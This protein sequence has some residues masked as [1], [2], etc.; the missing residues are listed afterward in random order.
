M[1]KTQ[2]GS[3]LEAILYP[4]LV[5]VIMWLV[6]WADHL[7][8][9]IPFY[10]YGV[11]PGVLE[12]WKGV[13][14]MPL[15]HS[16]EE[17]NHIFNNSIPTVVLLGAIIYYYRQIA[18]RVFFFSWIFTGIGVWLV[19][20]N[21]NSYHIGMSGVIYAMVGFLFISGI[22]RKYKPL[23]AISLF[24]VFMYGGMIWGIFPI[25]EKVSWEGHLSGLI[26]GVIL[27]FIYRKHGPQSPMYSYEIEKEMGIEPPDF[28]GELNERIRLAKLQQEEM[29]KQQLENQGQKIIYHFLPKDRSTRL[30]DDTD[31][32]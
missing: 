14:F 6:F 26:V 28:E 10:K 27:A 19:A 32:Q 18:F 3:P 7:F 2:F 24:V 23:Q 1:K 15:L 13:I 8:P 9:L 5:L 30:E 20:T 4:L 25:E 31:Q 22:I 16:Y 21:N 11:M 12:S 29:L 17:V